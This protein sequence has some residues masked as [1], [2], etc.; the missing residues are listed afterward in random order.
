MAIY[1]YDYF[2]QSMILEDKNT[3]DPST[4]MSIDA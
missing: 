1:D 3:L 2:G 4:D